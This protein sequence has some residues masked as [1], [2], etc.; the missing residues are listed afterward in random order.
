M[1]NTQQQD[2]TGAGNAQRVYK[3]GI[4]QTVSRFGA[5]VLIIGRDVSPNGHN[6]YFVEEVYK[7]NIETVSVREDELSTKA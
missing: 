4:G 7:G 5:R 2:K 6:V 3:Y 1:M